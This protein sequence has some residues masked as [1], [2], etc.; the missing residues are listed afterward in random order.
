MACTAVGCLIKLL[1]TGTMFVFHFV[2]PILTNSGKCSSAANRV[3][4]A[5]LLAICAFFCFFS[6]FTDS[7]IDPTNKNRRRYGIV[8]AKGLWTLPL[9]K[10][11]IKSVDLSRYRL[12]SVD[13]VHGALSMVVFAV[14]SLLDRNTLQCMYPGFKSTGNSMVQV[15][16]LVIGVV[17]GSVFMVFPNTRHGIGYPKPDGDDHDSNIVPPQ[18][19]PP[20]C[21][22]SI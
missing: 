1:P 20:K 15:I 12:R 17:A 19:P 5:T 10:A 13:F 7:Y 3:L 21:A 14:L 18:T 8:T 11:E 16:P 2:N 4:S 22:T 6:S 9:E